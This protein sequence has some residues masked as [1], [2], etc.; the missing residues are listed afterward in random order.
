VEN[1]VGLKAGV[2]TANTEFMIAPSEQHE[3]QALHL[4]VV[5]WPKADDDV[6]SAEAA[7]T[8]SVEAVTS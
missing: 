6:G 4:C 2:G 1:T 5:A 7:E 3:A 8:S